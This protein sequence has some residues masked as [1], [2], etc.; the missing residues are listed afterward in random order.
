M[1]TVRKDT[2]KR[3]SEK[4]FRTNKQHSYKN[5]NEYLTNEIKLAE[6]C[7]KFLWLTEDPM[8]ER[9]VYTV[10]GYMENDQLRKLD[11]YIKKGDTEFHPTHSIEY[12]QEQS[13][14]LDTSINELFSNQVSQNQ[15][16]PFLHR[17]DFYHHYSREANI[18]SALDQIEISWFHKK[19]L[20]IGLHEIY[21]DLLIRRRRP[22]P[23]SLNQRAIK[24]KY[25]FDRVNAKDNEEI[26][27]SARYMVSYITSRNNN[28]CQQI[29]Y[30]LTRDID[31]S[32]H[33]PISNYHSLKVMELLWNAE[34]ETREL[35]DAN[36]SRALSQR[37][38]RKKHQDRVPLNTQ[39]SPEARK[40]LKKLA[41]RKKKTQYEVLEELIFHEYRN[42]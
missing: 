4:T 38:H 18:L 31:N 20:L 25:I 34:G 7:E 26:L 15:A 5:I 23:P 30:T 35:F 32:T 40:Q 2:I 16:M 8:A 27:W 42:T 3:V 17:N 29:I 22:T 21:Q 24:K 33:T 12:Q 37:R 36:Y 19:K 13:W 41:T 10:L 9:F 39:I 28:S 1:N 6:S 14:F 11:R